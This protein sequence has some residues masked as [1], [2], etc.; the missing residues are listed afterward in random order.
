MAVPCS[1]SMPKPL[2]QPALLFAEP[3]QTNPQHTS[4]LPATRKGI[5]RYSVPRANPLGARPHCRKA[6]DGWT[7][8]CG[9]THRAGCVWGGGQDAGRPVVGV[10]RS[11]SHC[12][13]SPILWHQ[14]ARLQRGSSGARRAGLRPRGRG[15]VLPKHWPCPASAFLQAA[16]RRAGLAGLPLSAFL[17]P[18]ALGSGAS[19]ALGRL[20]PQRLRWP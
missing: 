5:K 12:G 17:A 1:P 9:G 2:P 20:L 15:S 14:Q 3:S 6:R 10:G 8:G 7:A 19:R 18:L 4:H 13:G 11:S 16:E